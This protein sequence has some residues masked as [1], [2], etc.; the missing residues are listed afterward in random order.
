MPTMTMS[1]GNTEELYAQTEEM[2]GRRL[3]AESL[4]EQHPDVARISEKWGRV[5]HHVDYSP[6]SGNRLIPIKEQS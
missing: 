1:G 4:V 3:M 2:D 5:Q 6:F